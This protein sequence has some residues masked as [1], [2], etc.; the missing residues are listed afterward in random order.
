M[1]S[2]DVFHDD[3]DDDLIR[4]KIWHEVMLNGAH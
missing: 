1:N 2:R 4:E 3:D